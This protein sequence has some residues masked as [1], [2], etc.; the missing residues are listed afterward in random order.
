MNQALDGT[1]EDAHLTTMLE[2]C[3]PTT[4]LGSRSAGFYTPCS[5]SSSEVQRHPLHYGKD[6]GGASVLQFRRSR[7]STGRA[8]GALRVFYSDSANLFSLPFEF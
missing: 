5:S 1:L 7:V 2:S 6:T 8:R 3:G 4:I